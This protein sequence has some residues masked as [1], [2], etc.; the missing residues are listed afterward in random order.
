MSQQEWLSKD[1]YKILGVSQD[2]SA[3][4]IKKAYRKKAKE[5]HPDRHPGDAKAEERFKEVGEAYSILS[6]AEQRKQYDAI[7]AMGAGGARFASGP[8]GAA[9]GGFEDLFGAF[10]G[11]GGFGGGAGGVNIEDIMGMFGGGSFSGASGAGRAGF[12]PNGGFG[13]QA[14][15]KGADVT[16]SVKLS[17]RD[18]VL[19]TEVSFSAAGRNITTR[20]PAGVHDGQKIR[21]RGKGQA[22]ASGGAPG[23]LMLTAHVASHPL[24]TMDGANLR[25]DIPITPSEAAFGAKVRVPLLDGGHVTMKVPAGMPSGRTLRAKGKG[26]RTK[27]GEGD[28]LVTLTIVLPDTLDENAEKA[29]RDFAEATSDFNPRADLA[30]L[31]AK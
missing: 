31:A 8:G 9:S 16:A 26:V 18:A 13:R 29:L 3:A 4:E 1:F 28:L 21:L 23:D 11:G 14:P 5:L 15:Q 19:G 27:K 12:S 30:E 7:R 25:V 10:T 17:F 20:I 24:Y 22:S 6:D 2:A